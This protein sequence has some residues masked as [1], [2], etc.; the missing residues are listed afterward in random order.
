M[1]RVASP[2]HP[3]PINI[4]DLSRCWQMHREDRGND[5]GYKRD[6]TTAFFDKGS[7]RVRVGII[8]QN[9]THPPAGPRVRP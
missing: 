6:Q 8:L 3:L 7:K 5:S 9:F 2:T 4:M 1:D